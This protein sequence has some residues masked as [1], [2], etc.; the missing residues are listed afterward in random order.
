MN[1]KIGNMNIENNTCDKLPVVEVDEK[2]NVNEH[3]DTITKKA[4]YRASTLSII[5]PFT[6]LRILTGKKHPKIKL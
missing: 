6:D 4:Y 5:F 3:V 1:L 2:P